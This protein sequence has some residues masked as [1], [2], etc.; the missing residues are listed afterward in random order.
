MRGEKTLKWELDKDMTD[1]YIDVLESYQA[2]L[3]YEDQG[4]MDDLEFLR[5]ERL[6]IWG[7]DEAPDVHA[8]LYILVTERR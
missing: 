8:E 4:V 2:R 7:D 1:F 6:A 3:P 5:T